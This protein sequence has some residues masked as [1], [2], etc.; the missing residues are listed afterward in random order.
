MGP[1]KD[2]STFPQNQDAAAILRAKG[3]RRRARRPRRR[4]CLL[5]GCGQ[6]FRPQQP[7][8]RYCSEACQTEARRWRR[9]KA[10]Q[11]YRQSLK[12][13][14][15]RRA[16]SRRYRERR[17]E[18]QAQESTAVTVARVIPTEFFFVLLRPPGMLCGI[19]SHPAVAPAAVLRSGLSPGTRT[20]SAAGEALARRKGAATKE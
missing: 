5:K 16:Q 6:V 14:Q 18:R 19:R 3:R 8:A 12:G 4:T 10:H 11:R 7:L 20:G 13:K 17:K 1:N 15:K 9:W 2:S